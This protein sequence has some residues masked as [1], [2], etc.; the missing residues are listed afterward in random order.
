MYSLQKTVMTHVIS[1]NL[2]QT[3]EPLHYVTVLSCFSARVD[4]TLVI[5]VHQPSP[6]HT[7]NKADP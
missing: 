6:I 5:N 1:K 2:T 7:H 4:K 3:L